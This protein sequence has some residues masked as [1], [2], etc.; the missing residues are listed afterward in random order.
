MNSTTANKK[1]FFILWAL[2]ILGS[3]SVLPYIQHLEI[4][5]STVSIW[6]IAL[7]G[8][9]QAVLFFGFICWVSYK[10]LPK[11]DL[12]PFPSLFGEHRLKRVVYP[13]LLAGVLVGLAIFLSDKTIFNSSLL[14]GAHPPFWTGALASIYG[15]VN[16][17]VLLRLF[18]FTLVY[19]LIGKCLR[20]HS[21]N[22][23]IILWSVNILVA[24]LFGIGHLP[25]AFKLAS[26]SGFEIFRVL[27]LN[28]I[29]GVIYGVQFKKLYRHPSPR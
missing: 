25:A 27:S 1:T 19:F 14:S 26:P 2:C 28:G 18:L 16:E 22:R 15:A 10:I 8:T 23:S 7:L 13:A 29:A 4:V 6:K 21:N 3:W 20:I 17:E 9:I 11:T 5:P 24:L 12:R